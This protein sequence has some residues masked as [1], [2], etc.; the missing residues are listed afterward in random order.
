MVKAVKVVN[1]YIYIYIFNHL[2]VKAALRYSYFNVIKKGIATEEDHSC[3]IIIVSYLHSENGTTLSMVSKSECVCIKALIVLY[4]SSL[5]IQLYIRA[6]IFRLLYVCFILKTTELNKHNVCQYEKV[7]VT[8]KRS[9]IF[10][11]QFQGSF[12]L[13][14]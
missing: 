6:N 14:R 4:L 11:A 5:S 2:T 1:I 8:L 10:V 3:V 9:A 13:S 7:Q 12:R